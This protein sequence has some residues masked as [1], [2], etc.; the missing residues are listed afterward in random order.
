[1]TSGFFEQRRPHGGMTYAQYLRVMAEQAGEDTG[2]L[3][4]SEAERVAYT[5]LNLQ[6]SERIGRTHEVREA[7]RAAV[8]A[9]ETPQLW[10][11]LTEPWCGD[12]AQCLPHIAKLAGLN[13]AID[14]RILPRDQNLDIM[15]Q[16]LT[17]GARSIPKL[18]AFDPAGEELFRWGPRPAV[19]QSIFEQAK[20]EGLEKPAILERVH[21]WYGRDRG[22][23]I[24]R[25]FEHILDQKPEQQPEQQ[26][27]QQLGQQPDQQP[28]QQLGQQ[29]DQQPGQ[30]LEFPPR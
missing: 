8:L 30:K 28:G 24:E 4:A 18:V 27:D 10:M 7:L 19:L 15:D 20:A 17:R 11:V 23:E 6:R 22:V 9:M 13:P 25:E 26:P 16:Y 21:L 2:G 29:S 1:M 12:S 3:T 5:K 14:L